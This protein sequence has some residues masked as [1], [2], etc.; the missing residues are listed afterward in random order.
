MDFPIDDIL[1]VG[2]GGAIALGIFIGMVRA[3]LVALSVALERVVDALSQVEQRLAR[4]EATVQ[5][6]PPLS[7]APRP[8]R[9]EG[10]DTAE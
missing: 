1:K 7:L 10:G 3:R 4:L 5:P 8:L 2:S 6:Q 9:L